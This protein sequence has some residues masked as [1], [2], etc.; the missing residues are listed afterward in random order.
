GSTAQEYHTSILPP[1]E[2]EWTYQSFTF[3]PSHAHGYI[4]CQMNV[5]V[6]EEYRRFA[7]FVDNFVLSEV[8]SSSATLSTQSKA[9]P[10]PF[11]E[12]LHIETNGSR[13][14]IY[15]VMGKLHHEQE[16]LSGNKNSILLGDLPIGIYILK[17]FND[18]GQELSSEKV[19]K[20]RK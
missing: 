5:P 19:I 13:I 8:S 20:I 4:Y 1:S 2:E 16:V 6:C 3:Q 18:D 14:G 17:A 10:N 7:C 12:A 11:T 9:Y 15:D